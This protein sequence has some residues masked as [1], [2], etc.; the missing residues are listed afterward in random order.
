MDAAPDL[1]ELFLFALPQEWWIAKTRRVKLKFTIA[2]ASR[3][4]RRLSFGN[5]G[6]HGQ[7][8][9]KQKPSI[10]EKTRHPRRDHG[11]GH[12]PFHRLY[13]HHELILI[14]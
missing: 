5:L 6:Q 12:N 11:L 10:Y 1:P 2:Q 7:P 9:I 4:G 14:G 8:R 3:R 13:R